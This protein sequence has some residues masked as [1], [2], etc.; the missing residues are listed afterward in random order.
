M[1]A[2]LLALAG[3]AF[4]IFAATVVRGRFVISFPIAAATFPSAETGPEPPRHFPWWT[5][6][7]VVIALVFAVLTLVAVRR[8]DNLATK[9]LILDNG[10]DPSRL[11]V[12]ALV[13]P[14]QMYTHETKKIVLNVTER[15]RPAEFRDGRYVSW[16]DV[17]EAKAHSQGVQIDDA[18]AM[19]FEL[20]DQPLPI[21]WIVRAEEQGTQT[22]AVSVSK[23]KSA[24][25]RSEI[26]FRETA[27]IVVRP[28]WV[29]P[30][31]LT[32]FVTLAT[33]IVSLIGALVKKK[34]DA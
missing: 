16:G 24:K 9:T 21:V 34:E 27:E 22:V 12:F 15:Q 14:E 2:T 29:T 20:K 6:A 28:V 33:G 8:H 1:T 19:P 4:A 32:G 11:Y 30:E 25:D 31:S 23:M 18:D 13:Y 10:R 26:I 17:I 3:V 7:G 5:V